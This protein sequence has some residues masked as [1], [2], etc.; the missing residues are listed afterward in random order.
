M[1]LAQDSLLIASGIALLCLPRALR[2]QRPQALDTVVV[3]GSHT[4]ASSAISDMRSVAIIDRARIDGSGARTVPELLSTVMGVDVDSRSPAQA[5][6]SIRGSSPEQIVILV[7]GVRVSDVQ[8]AHYA[9]DLAVPLQSIERIEIL[10]GAGSAVY[11]PDA[12]GGVINIV[13]RGSTPRS[14]E[15]HGGS[16]GSVG[17]SLIDGASSG[18]RSVIVSGDFDKSDGSRDDTDYRMGQGRAKLAVPLADGMVTTN[19]GVGVRDFGASDFYAP[20]NS[21]ERTTTTTVDSRWTAALGS[22]AL[23]A[24]GGTRRH[25]DHYVLVR[26]NPSLYE[27][28]HTTWQTSGTATARHDVGPAVVALGAEADHDQLSSLR[29]GGRREWRA[30]AFAEVSTDASSVVAGNAGV[31]D[32][33]SSAYGDFFSPSAAVRVKLADALQLHASASR[34]FRAPTWTERYYTDPSNNGDPDLRPERFSSG[35]AGARLIGSAATFD[36]TVFGRQASDLID[37]VRPLGSSAATPWQAT[38]IGDA[39]FRGIEAVLEPRPLGVLGTSLFATGLSF[40]S[41]ASAAVE[42]KYAL[43]PLTRQIGMRLHTTTNPFGASVDLESAQRAGETSYL[44]GNARL[45]WTRGGYRLTLDA[46]NIANAS[47]LDASGMPVAGRG[48]YAGVEWA[49]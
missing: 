11:G 45:W 29:L 17:G 13:T 4:G 40:T 49:R 22:W 35:D 33:H 15:V 1:R 43:R 7:D 48:L 12:V 38:N 31:R 36:V 6:I 42:G 47:W 5:D 27:N 19:L 39:T 16:F 9:S 14:A 20:Y 24:A 32:D 28:Y 2:A 18:A 23:D 44:N 30:G 25:E 8:S 3:V 37:W 26:G 21:I 46:K 41:S 10:R 34:G